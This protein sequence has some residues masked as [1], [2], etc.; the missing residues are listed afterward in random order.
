MTPDVFDGTIYSNPERRKQLLGLIG[1]AY[2]PG[3]TTKFSR[4]RNFGDMS[5]TAAYSI[6]FADQKFCED[7]M[8]AV[9]R[10]RRACAEIASRYSTEAVKEILS[11]PTPEP[12]K[13]P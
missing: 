9:L 8:K 11:R 6:N 7:A 12:E 4:A 1:S 2:I 5:R 13:A 3:R 10:E